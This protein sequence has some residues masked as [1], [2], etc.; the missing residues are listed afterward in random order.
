MQ[1]PIPMSRYLLLFALL[2]L[3]FP[4]DAQT[5]VVLNKYA[6]VISRVPCDNTFLV[7]TATNFNVGDTILMIQMKG[8]VIDT[9]NTAAFGD[10]LGYKGAGNYEY[11]VIKA[12][13]GNAITLRYKLK[14]TYDI[15]EGKVQF[16][17]VASYQSYTLTQPLTCLPWNGSKGGVFA[18]IVANTLNL[19]YDINVSGK[20]FTGGQPN[21]SAAYGCNR[22]DYFYPPAN[23]EGGQKGEGI[24]IISNTKMYGRGALANGGGGGNDHNAGGGGGSNAANAGLGGNQY[25][26][27]AC[28]VT[29][30]IGGV[31]GKALANSALINRSFLGGGGGCG[32]GNDLS[33]KAGGTGGGIVF[34]MAGTIIGNSSSIIANG[35]DAP[36]CTA[37]APGC[38]DDGGGGGGGA[39]SIFIRTTTLT[40]NANVRAN[41]GK[42]SNIYVS[43]PSTTQVAPGGGGSGGLIGFASGTVPAGFTTTANGGMNGI[44]PQFAGSPWGAQPGNAGQVLV[45]M[46]LAL[47][48]PAD[49][50]VTA[51]LTA[52]FIDSFINCN[53]RKFLDRTITSSIGVTSWS[54]NFGDNTTSTLQ[55]PVHTYTNPGTYTV[56]LVVSDN[57]ACKDSISKSVT[58]YPCGDTIINAYAAVLGRVPCANTYLVDTATSFNVGDTILVIQMK[59]AIA[60]TTN[61]A[62]FG[63][64]LDYK[65]AGNYEYNII[66]AKTGN[67]LTLK[68]KLKRGYE[69]PNGKVQFVRVPNYQNYTTYQRLTCLPWT[70]SKGGVLVMNIANTLT[71]N[72]DIDVSS[73]G[74]K[75][76]PSPVFSGGVVNCNN[77]AY[78]QAPNLDNSAAKGEGISPVGVNNS[79]ARGKLANAGGGGN[80]HNAGGGGGSNAGIGGIGGHAYGGCNA[81]PPANITGG[82]GGTNLIINSATN[83]IFLGGGG[84]A[85]HAN[86][87]SNAA[88]GNGGGIIIINAG[89]VTSAGGNIQAN[90]GDAP[91]CSGSG[92]PNDCSDGMGGGGGGGTVLLRVTGYSN[93]LPVNAKGGKGADVTWA[94][95]NPAV[96]IMGPGGGGG[97]G[98][99]WVSQATVPGALS[100]N[101]TGGSNGGN[102]SISNNPSWGAVPGTAGTSVTNLPDVFPLPADTFANTT[103]TA[104][105]IDSFIS[106][107]T[108]KFIDRSVTAS[109]S[110]VSWSWNFGD[111]TTSTLQSPVHTY[112]T[113]G[114]YTVKLVVT[115]NSACK[116]SISRSVTIN[117]CGDTII[118]RYAAVL[119]RGN[120]ENSFLVDTAT[121]FNVG[122]TVLMI[123]MKGAVIDS[124]NTAAFGNMTQLNGAGNYEYNVIQAKTGNTLTLRYKVV[125]QYEIPNGK[126]QFVR[127][128]NYSNYTINVRHSCMPWNGTKGGVF[129]MN[130]TNTLTMNDEINVSGQGF[131]GGQINNGN[132]FVCNRY[133]Y[134]YPLAGNDGGQKGEGITEINALMMRGKGKLANG[135]GGGNNTNAGGAGGSNAGSGG[136]GGHQWISCDTSAA[137]GGAGGLALGYTAINNRLYLGGGGGAGQEN[138]NDTDPGGNGAGIIIIHANTLA[139]NSRP[140][141]AN[142]ANCIDNNSVVPPNAGDGQ[143]GGGG[144]G[145]IL[146]DVASFS[147]N[148]VVEARGGNGG[149]LYA[150]Q[151]HGPG[152]GGGGGAVLFR[153]VGLPATSINVTGGLNGTVIYVN[154]MAHS[155]QPGQPGTTLSGVPYIL[156]ADTFKP[157]T[158]TLAFT[159]STLNCNTRK[160]NNQTTTTTT[161]IASWN[162]NFGDGLTSTL[163]SPT[164]MYAG[165]GTYTVKL[166][167]AD[168]NACKD[169]LTKTVVIN[170]TDT[171]INKYAAILERVPCDNSFLVDTATGFNVGDTVLMIQMKG[172]VID[173]SNTAA[174]GTVLNYNG[175]GNYEYNVIKARTGNILTL[176]YKLARQ[177]NI[178]DGKVQ[179]VRVVNAQNYVVNKQHSCMPWNGSKG[180]VFILNAS[181]TVTL[182]DNINVAGTG[183][184]GGI[185]NTIYTANNLYNITNYYL[186]GGIDSGGQKGE[187]IAAVSASRSYGRGALANG[188]GGGNAH[189]AGGGGGS[190]ATAG[191][192]GGCQHNN[193][194]SPTSNGIGG[195]GLTYNTALN[196]LFLGGGGGAAHA[197]ENGNK[198]GGNGGGII[199]LNAATLVGSGGN[200]VANGANAREYTVVSPST[201]NDGMGGGGGGGVIALQV[202]NYSGSVS[203]ISN[204][205]KGANVLMTGIPIGPTGPGGGGS[206]GVL[207]VSGAAV[208]PSVTQ[209]LAGGGSGVIPLLGNIPYGSLPGTAGQALTA[210]QLSFPAIAD[211]FR[212]NRFT[213]SFTDSAVNCFSRKLKNS[214]TT[215]ATGIASWSWDAGAAGTSAV[216]SPVFTFPGYGTYPVKLIAV[217]S[218]G[219]KDSITKNIVIPYVHFANAGNDTTT[220]LGVATMLHARGGVSYSWTPAAS[221]GNPNAAQTTA[222]PTVHTLYIVT[223]TDSIGCTDKDTVSVLLVP[224]AQ[225]MAGPS[226]TSVCMGKKVPLFAGGVRSYQWAPPAGLNNTTI[227]NP[228]ATF[229]GDITYVVTGRDSS[230][231]MS[232]DTVSIREQPAPHVRASLDGNGKVDCFVTTA[233]LHATGALT[234]TW[235]P[236]D[237]LN[238]DSI[239]NPVATPLRTAYFTVTGTDAF[240]C[241]AKDSILIITELQAL[242]TV[243]D[244]F[245]PNGDGRNDRIRPLIYC[246]F[247]LETFEIFNRWGQNV[248]KAFRVDEGWNGMVNGKQADL[249][250]YMWYARGHRTNGESVIYKGTVDLI[251]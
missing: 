104:N 55:N 127:V 239:A 224:G 168:S 248:Y 56:K 93:T 80:A 180:G 13:T 90:G 172:A 148:P 242:V 124:S 227:P 235:M 221:L 219:C 99:L 161:G 244:A 238:N 176:K 86:N 70:G 117:P 4:A 107:D 122:D 114:T 16:V 140:I 157:N 152:G 95:F 121:G 38:R 182:G 144:G 232:F 87:N 25:G 35:A 188:G 84:G 143:S 181:G 91:L 147:S 126:V 216:H 233:Q 106:C 36:E 105:F 145:A 211:T 63:N 100:F 50:F 241:S 75:G 173:T 79:Y 66:T 1:T 217:D 139:G 108:R 123:Q 174:F 189:N 206:G 132:T 119:N 129:T 162:W 72:N 237:M 130:V 116:D 159:D 154:N 215:T 111:N 222:E 194:N 149:N 120:C 32:Q 201:S 74:F 57:S 102:T 113:P 40:G 52:N 81:A 61:T 71:L 115:D 41:G 243:P 225:V 18:M 76:A 202:N 6:A 69:I 24:T 131:R 246:D 218:N 212:I 65:S 184:R 44:L 187:G 236:A 195:I 133:D 8:A 53:T 240:G 31:G 28:A 39:G 37:P 142:G 210:F 204:G 85:G 20:G 169:S 89:N 30:N 9:S 92:G 207:W 205:G 134:F 59:G 2:F 64:V 42:G 34:L 191:G 164:H 214:S 153:T 150:S 82:I 228:V 192:L 33:E 97:G 183:F 193:C 165:N 98:A 12:K 178:P 58:I 190:N 101:V 208:S 94:V 128:P 156:P 5:P 158:I 200:V 46:P 141:K 251:R 185:A 199:I 15:P 223:V 250:T 229:S 43:V 209:N 29:P 7:D 48:L 163:Q 220:C 26:L 51:T 177:Y 175:A 78:A 67:A 186:G 47:P 19:L 245:T 110:T 11:N 17:R 27:G 138:N 247:I 68:Y 230:G 125:R 118:N 196:K 249:G 73:K 136:V 203:T 54:W 155:A 62:A 3:T 179:L 103:L 213:L 83:K 112:T 170:C 198:D 23:N 77:F 197:N 166:V 137:S 14:R 231:C 146:L 109:T 234:Y 21:L 49:T 60:D 88:G 10:V 160:F 22:T 167:V 45:N 135:G 96:N 226:D 151:I 171:I